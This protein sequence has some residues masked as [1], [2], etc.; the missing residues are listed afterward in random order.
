MWG[1]HGV[2][3]IHNFIRPL[4]VNK[5][6]DMQKNPYWL[7]PVLEQRETSNIQVQQLDHTCECIGMF[8]GVGSG[9]APECVCNL[10][11]KKTVVGWSFE[12]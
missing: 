4:D 8:L 2:S 7:W 1:G 10:H 9:I 11:L 5:G 12:K 3:H 6:K